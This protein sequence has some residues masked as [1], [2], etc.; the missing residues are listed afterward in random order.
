MNWTI[1]LSPISIPTNEY[2]KIFVVAVPVPVAY[3]G[4]MRQWAKIA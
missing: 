4:G 1:C 2:G 3:A